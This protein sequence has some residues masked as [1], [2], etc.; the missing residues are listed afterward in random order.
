MA[1]RVQAPVSILM[2]ESLAELVDAIERVVQDLPAPELRVLRLRFGIGSAR[3]SQR[4]VARRLDLSVSAVR[5]LE[6]RALRDL[7][8]LSLPND[9]PRCRTVPR[10]VLPPRRPV[11]STTP[12]VAHAADDPAQLVG[13]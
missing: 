11:G 7:R 6:R 9:V 5:R 4:A 10:G 1:R 13:C 2:N 8:A 3:H 12:H